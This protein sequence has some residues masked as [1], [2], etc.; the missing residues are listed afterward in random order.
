[1]YVGWCDVGWVP[2]VEHETLVGLWGL[3]A[4]G[5]LAPKQITGVAFFKNQGLYSEKASFSKE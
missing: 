1:M 2:I 5:V 4:F 3:C